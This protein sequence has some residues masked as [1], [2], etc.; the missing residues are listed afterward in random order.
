MTADPNNE[1]GLNQGSRQDDGVGSNPD[2]RAQD[3]H[4]TSKAIDVFGASVD[5][6]DKHF[7]PID[8]NKEGWLKQETQCGEAFRAGAAWQSSQ[9][10]TPGR[11]CSHCKS[12]V[13]EQDPDFCPYCAVAFGGRYQLEPAEK[14]SGI[15]PIDMSDGEVRRAVAAQ[16]TSD[17]CGEICGESRCVLPKGHDGFHDD[18]WPASP[19]SGEHG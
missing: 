17:P 3:R 16:K 19:R 11:Q 7:R 15:S 9:V 1:V 2:L 6:C 18:E 12:R 5:W 13:V 14:A 10:E 8:I 4:P